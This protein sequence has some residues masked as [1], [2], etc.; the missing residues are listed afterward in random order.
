MDGPQFRPYLLTCAMVFAAVYAVALISQRI[1][2]QYWGLEAAQ[3]GH[4]LLSD[5][6]VSAD[7]LPTTEAS[8]PSAEFL[9]DDEPANSGR[10]R[11]VD[12]AGFVSLQSAEDGSEPA[13]RARLKR[14]PAVIEPEAS[15][16]MMTPPG[17]VRIVSETVEQSADSQSSAKRGDE[18]P[19]HF[20]TPTAAQ[21]VPVRLQEVIRDEL[22]DVSDEELRTWEDQ[23]GGMP[24]RQVRELLRFRKQFGLQQDAIQPDSLLTTGSSEQPALPPKAK[25]EV[26]PQQPSLS[27]A[28][29]GS[30]LVQDAVRVFRLEKQVLLHNL[31]NARTIGF[32]RSRVVYENVEPSS[33][34]ADGPLPFTGEISIGNGVRM[35]ETEI[36][37]TQGC[38]VET[39]QST[40][41]AIDGDAFCAVLDSRESSPRTLYARTGRLCQDDQRQLALKVGSRTFPLDPS[42]HAL[43]E[44]TSYQ[45]SADGIVREPAEGETKPS[46]LGSIRL[47]RFPRPHALQPVGPGLFAATPRSG[48]AISLSPAE[49]RQVHVKQGFRE[50]SNVDVEQELAELRQLRL[51]SDALAEFDA[52]ET[53]QNRALR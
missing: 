25:R 30:P 22:P 12:S 40:D 19:G 11:M 5:N 35:A 50:E 37:P 52:D 1:T 42:S 13:G 15:A 41:I 17:Q 2:H 7:S 29:E 24:I 14:K 31:V 18:Q 46:T 32:K 33:N 53:N 4:A 28:D 9:A 16:R 8:D 36:C 44:V 39:G 47:V 34:D 51:L 21:P 3:P 45:V 48:N 49:R 20:A 38:L 43:V 23:L 10:L 27:G 26:T 6:S